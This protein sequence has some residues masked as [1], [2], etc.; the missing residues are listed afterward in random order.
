[1]GKPLQNIAA[2]TVKSF[3]AE[4]WIDRRGRLIG[5]ITG[6]WDIVRGRA[7]PARIMEF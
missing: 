5:N 3:A 4:P 1:L 2:N 6:L 7:H